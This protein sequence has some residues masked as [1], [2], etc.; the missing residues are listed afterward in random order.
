M[1]DH[2]SLMAGGGLYKRLYEA[3]NV[4]PGLVCPV[5]SDTDISRPTGAVAPGS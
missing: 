4:D 2:H 3:Q 5:P 1:G